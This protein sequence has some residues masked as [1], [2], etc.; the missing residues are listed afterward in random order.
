MFVR[1]AGPATLNNARASGI[2]DE[3]AGHA[4]MSWTRTA[5][6]QPI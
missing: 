5:P 2:R 3:A 6:R 4:T 1:V